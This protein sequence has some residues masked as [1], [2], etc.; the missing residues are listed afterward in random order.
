MT[1][2]RPKTKRYFDA[3]GV[4]HC[5]VYISILRL[6]RDR[7]DRKAR[8]RSASSFGTAGRFVRQAVATYQREISKAV[9][10]QQSLVENV[11]VNR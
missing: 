8:S 5:Q 10:L 1:Q 2:P 6:A 4:R 7:P 3:L 9:L 11:I